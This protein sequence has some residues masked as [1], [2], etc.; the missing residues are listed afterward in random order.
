MV[1]YV[2]KFNI[3]QKHVKMKFRFLVKNPNMLHIG[4]KLSFLGVT[5]LNQN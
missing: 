5:N 4:V 2:K 1:A 3:C